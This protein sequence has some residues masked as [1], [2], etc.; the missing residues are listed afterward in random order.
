[1]AAKNVV[2]VNTGNVQVN[3]LALTYRAEKSHTCILLAIISILLTSCAQIQP[4]INTPN[5]H[6]PT[7]ALPSAWTSPATLKYESTGLT[8]TST[9]NLT[10]WWKQFQDSQ[11]DNLISTGL[12]GNLELHILQ[13]RL[14]QARLRRKQAISELSPSLSASTGIKS[15]TSP[16]QSTKNTYEIGFDASWEVDIFGGFQKGIEAATADQAVSEAN[17]HNARVSLVA[18]IARNYI[19]LCA[20]QRRL[21]I[22]QNSLARQSEI[23]QITEWLYQSGLTANIDVEQAKTNN[24]QTRATIPEFAAGK[25]KAENRLAVLLGLNPGI[26][27]TQLA[28]PIDLPTLPATIGTGIPANVLRQRPDI[29]A[30]ERTLAAE[31]ARV[32]Q[33]IAERFPSLKLDASFGW[34]AYSLSALSGFSALT[35]II[36][37]YLVATLFDGGRLL[38]AIDIQNSVQKQALLAYKNSVLNALEEIENALIAYATTRERADALRSATESARQAALLARNL[39]QAGITDFQKVLDS[40]R[41][42]LNV[43]DSLAVTEANVCINMIQLYKTLGG[44]WEQNPV[45]SKSP[46]L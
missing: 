12:A 2:V 43:E 41:T 38:N 39:Y 37:G 15:N 7:L 33:R 42:Q 8:S 28:K 17:F 14:N 46:P 19:E 13:A 21:A 9:Q 23:L 22:A 3:K 10:Q 34:Q 1:M 5:Y 29:I 30:T 31:T 25:A 35:R 45:E 26:L 36:S 18:E 24:E 4:L 6:P 20:Y 32:G 16:N 27:H 44:G 11:L 40:E